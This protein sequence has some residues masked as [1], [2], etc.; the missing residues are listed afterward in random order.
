LSDGTNGRRA[1]HKYATL[2]SVLTPADVSPPLSL[3][4]RGVDWP[5]QITQHA[6]YTCPF[7]GKDTI[8]RQVTGIWKCSA[9]KK[10]SAGGAYTLK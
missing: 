7:C 6:R 2:I 8:K 5:E 10:I 1:N 3:Y 4:S 9:C